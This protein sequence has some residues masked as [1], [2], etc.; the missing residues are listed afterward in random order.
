MQI[1]VC[2]EYLHDLCTMLCHEREMNRLRT[3]LTAKIFLAIAA[4]AVL[5]VGIMALLVALSMRYGFSQYLLRGELIRFD[6]LVQEL[7]RTYDP[8]APGWP[9]LAA[10][11]HVWCDFVR[12]HFTPPGGTDQDRVNAD[13]LMIGDRL[14][15]LDASG[16]YIAGTTA[17]TGVFQRRPICLDRQCSGGDRLGYIRLNAPLQADAASDAF[18]L[19]GQL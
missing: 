4:T 14:A 5:V 18:F 2:R 7:A 16:T 6:K 10:E 12:A 17:R 13:T 1:G 9:D 15:L 11:P 19:R 3:S 8:E